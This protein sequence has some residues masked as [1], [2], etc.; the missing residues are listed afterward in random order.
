MIT[1]EQLSDEIIVKYFEKYSRKI[2]ALRPHKSPTKIEKNRSKFGGEPNLNG[3]DNY[4]CCK[5][6]KTPLNHVVQIYKSE[7]PDFYFPKDKVLFQIYRCP[8]ADCPESFNEHHDFTTFYFYFS[9][10]ELAK[11][12]EYDKPVINLD[13][14][15]EELIECYLKPESVIDLPSWG[16]YEEIDEDKIK[17]KFGEEW[18]DDEFILEYSAHSGSKINGYPVWIQGANEV[19]CSCGKNKELFFQL[20]SE[21]V[22]DGV[23]YPPAPDNWSG[24]GLMIGDLGYMYFFVC[25]ACGETSIEI[26]WECS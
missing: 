15:E 24:H 10:S 26:Q 16:D 9:E 8:N 5:H 17:V 25:K 18:F 11:N 19:K 6:C 21:D 20:S 3:F 22:E 12:K 7:F 23:E 2:T 13:N 4:P 1:E 14:F